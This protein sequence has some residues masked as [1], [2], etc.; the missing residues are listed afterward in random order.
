MELNK[1]L[2]LRLGSVISIIGSGGKTTLMYLLAKELKNENKVLVTTTTKIYKPK[3]DEVDFLALGNESFNKLK[4][5]CLK[6][7]YAY[8]IFINDD[9]KLVGVKP[10][11]LEAKF[12][13]FDYS[14]IEADGSKRKSIKGWNSNE[15]IVCNKTNK[16]I[17]IISIDILGKE[18]NECNVHRVKEF[19]KITNTKPGEEVNEKNILSVIFN[20]DGLFKRAK[21]E[22]ILFIN[23]ID[24]YKEYKDSLFLLKSIKESNEK[25]NIIDKII[26]GSLKNMKF[27]ILK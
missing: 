3:K 23:K 26:F 9:N 18:I 1:V 12:K 22:K 13:Y 25:N 17:G 14:I 27:E 5:S 20:K 24:S 8:G 19:N 15:P 21:G 10:E 6:G 2:E 4:N 16:T 7:I 11:D